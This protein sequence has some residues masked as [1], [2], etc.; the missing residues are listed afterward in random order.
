M[1]NGDNG[2]WI[3]TGQNQ[4]MNEQGRDTLIQNQ[5]VLC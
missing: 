3:R 2:E 1:M 5:N 4:W